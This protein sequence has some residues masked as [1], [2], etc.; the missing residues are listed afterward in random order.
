[1]HESRSPRWAPVGSRAAA[2]RISLAQWA[3]SIAEVLAELIPASRPAGRPRRSLTHTQRQTWDLDH[4]Q[5]F[6]AWTTETNSR[7]ALLVWGRYSAHDRAH[8]GPGGL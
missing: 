8:D 3:A 2:T 1:M 5:R 6:R 4:A 7:P